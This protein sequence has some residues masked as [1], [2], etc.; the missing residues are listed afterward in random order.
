MTAIM[1]IARSHTTGIK[2]DAFPTSLGMWQTLLTTS[3]PL[4]LIQTDPNSYITDKVYYSLHLY[5]K[6]GWVGEKVVGPESR[7][8]IYILQETTCVPIPL[9]WFSSTTSTRYAPTL[10]AHGDRTGCQSNPNGHGG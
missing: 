4:N 3:I 10:T 6:G 8:T 7:I 2:A 5:Q 1:I 9:D